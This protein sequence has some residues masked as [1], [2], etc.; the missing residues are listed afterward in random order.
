MQLCTFVHALV[1]IIK[2]YIVISFTLYCTRSV[3]YV[4]FPNIIILVMQFHSPSFLSLA[5]Q[6]DST[7]SRVAIER[8]IMSIDSYLVPHLAPSLHQVPFLAGI[9]FYFLQEDGLVL[10]GNG[11]PAKC[12]YNIMLPMMGSILYHSTVTMVSNH[13]LHFEA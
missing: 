10:R 11:F 13:L 5:F 7:A 8:D 1:R 6:V 2:S 9:F 4:Y 3:S 12:C